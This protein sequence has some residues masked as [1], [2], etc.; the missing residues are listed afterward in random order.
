MKAKTV[1]LMTVA[2]GF[3]LVAAWATTQL[4]RPTSTERVDVLVASRDI[5]A[6]TVLR[7]PEDFFK[8]KPFIKGEE[9]KN[10]INRMDVLKGKV[11]TKAMSAD[12]FCTLGHLGDK[13]GLEVA[14]GMRA[15]AVQV[16]SEK[17]A[18]GFV[19]PK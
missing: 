16:T 1:V 19:L 17:V 14:K 11:V 15:I 3:G 18:G 8:A 7:K 10:A 12:Q 9:P 2:I 4:A 13:W 6:G 5:P